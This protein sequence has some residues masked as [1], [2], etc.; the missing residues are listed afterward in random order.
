MLRWLR[1]GNP[2]GR[3]IIPKK[4]IEM[5]IENLDKNFAKGTVDKEGL[6]AYSPTEKPFGLYGIFFD[7]ERD[8]FARMP[9]SESKSVSYAVDVLSSTTAGGRIRFSTDSQ[10]IGVAAKWKYLVNKMGTMPISG[11]IG[12]VLLEEC[13]NGTRRY[14]KTFFPNV[15]EEKEGFFDVV[16]VCG[17]FID[18]EKKVRDFIM[19]CPLYNDYITEIQVL[20][21]EG[22]TIG[23]GKKYK[24]VLPIVYYGSSI[25]QGGCVSRAD[26]AYEGFIESW[27]NVDFVNLGFSGN[28]RGEER[29]AEYIANL[30][31]S[32]FV[33]DYDY[34]APTVGHLQ[35]THYPFYKIFRE[36]QPKTPIL[37]MSRHCFD[38][39]IKGVAERFEVIKE[40][41]LRARAEGDE[42]VYLLD[43]SAFFDKEIGCHGLVDF[44]HP[45]DVGHFAMAKSV[46]NLLKNLLP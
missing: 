21:D 22:A 3:V 20:L 38:K 30:R 14:I 5:K 27:T 37:L 36:K 4:I 1:S 10:R 40:T 7:K 6:V 45:N 17:N 9:H 33:F 31:C 39:K 28:A 42:N 13:E 12:F 29:M 41:Y 11:Y 15:D 25:T 8:C 16:D 35:N 24:D 23:E 26:N 18:N 44:A 34:N 2:N 32:V 19:Y 43:G 46:Y